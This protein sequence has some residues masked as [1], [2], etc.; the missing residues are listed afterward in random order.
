MRDEQAAPAH[1]VPKNRDI[2]QTA[3]AFTRTHASR[4]PQRPYEPVPRLKKSSRSM[5]L[6]LKAWLS[7]AESLTLKVLGFA[8]EM[9]FAGYGYSAIY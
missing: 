2:T 5:S 4:P 6:E 9:L 8:L 7:D 3:C 1:E